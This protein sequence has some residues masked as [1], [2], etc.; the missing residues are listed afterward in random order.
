M[1]CTWHFKI[2]IYH[3]QICYDTSVKCMVAIVNAS[4][5]QRTTRFSLNLCFFLCCLFC[6]AKPSISCKINSM[7]CNKKISVEA[8]LEA[9][10]LPG[11]CSLC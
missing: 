4:F 3:W 1:C 6:V 9:V 11:D 10:G 5:S 7:P 2:S 8:V